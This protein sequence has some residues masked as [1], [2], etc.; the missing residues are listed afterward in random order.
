MGNKIT[1]NA[2]EE[3]AVEIVHRKAE[4]EFEQEDFI[5]EIEGSIESEYEVL[6]PCLQHNEFYELRKVIHI[7]TR[8][9]RAVYIVNKYKIRSH[10]REMF[11]QQIR[12]LKKIDHP[13]VSKIY[14]LFKNDHRFFVVMEYKH[15]ASLADALEE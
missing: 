6:S 10:E 13:A 14:E 1:G 11:E 2:S 5:R 8:L 4:M 7:K 3:S 9:V 15:G 12:N